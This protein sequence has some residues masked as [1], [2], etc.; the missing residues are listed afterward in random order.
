MSGNPDINAVK[1]CLKNDSAIDKT[2]SVRLS[3][4]L[5]GFSYLPFGRINLCCRQDKIATSS[6]I[7]TPAFCNLRSNNTVSTKK[8]VVCLLTT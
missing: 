4:E 6:G 5:F 7:A 3:E 8:L 1:I 2:Y